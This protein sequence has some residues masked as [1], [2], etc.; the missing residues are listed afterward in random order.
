M[1]I[2]AFLFSIA[3]FGIVWYGI[4]IYFGFFLI[5]GYSALS[6]VREKDDEKDEELQIFHLILSGVL[7]FFIAFYIGKSAFP[8]AWNNLRG[9]YYNEY[10]YST[11]SQEESIFAYRSDYLLPIATMNLESIP[12]IF[13]GIAEQM[14]SAQIKEFFEKTDIKN[15]PLESLHA[16][17]MKYRNSPDPALRADIKT[18]GQHIYTSVLYPPQENQNMGGIYRI[19]TFMT[20]LINENRKRYLDDSLVSLF[21]SYLYDPS[22]E[23]TI[24]KMKSL[25]LKYLLVDL[26]AATIDRDPRHALTDRAEKLLIT[27]NAKNLKLVTTDN[28]CLELALNERKK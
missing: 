2:Y 9:A 12:K 26:N 4:I 25:G 19:G 10:K 20:Y 24:E 5:M 22:P 3:A 13:D 16:F 15:L 14:K 23:K 27:M 6:F 11:L 28:S 8:H 7:F 18:L 17:I 1:G 21:G